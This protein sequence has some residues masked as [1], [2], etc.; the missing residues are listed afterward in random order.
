MEL[1]LREDSTLAPVTGAIVRLIGPA[2]VAAQGLSDAFGRLT[3]RA[4]G[5]GIYRI[6][7][8]RIGMSGILTE[9]Y[10]LAAGQTY[11]R[12][13]RL[14]ARRTELPP[15]V[16]EGRSACSAQGRGGPLASALWEEVRKA[17]TANVLTAES[18]LPLHQREFVRE[19]D[20]RRQPLREWVVVSRLIRGQ[21]FG[22]LAAPDLVRNGFVQEVGDSALFAAPDAGTLLSDAFVATHCFRAVP[23]PEGLLGLAFEPVRGRR[24]PDVA[25]TLWVRR[26]TAELLALEYS[27]T[28]LT[29][30][31]RRAALGGRIEYERLASGAWIVG[32]WHVRM[33]RIAFDLTHLGAGRPPA[34]LAGYLD[35]GGRARVALDTLGR[36]DRAVLLGAIHDSTTGR[37]LAGAFV[38]VLGTADSVLTDAQGRFELAVAAAGD[39]R[40][41]A[42]HPKLG[43][44]GEATSK[45]VLLSLGDTARVAFGVPS[46][47]TFVA[48]LCKDNTKSGTVGIV[49]TAWTS[50]GHPAARREVRAVRQTVRGPIPATTAPGG[51][52]SRSSPAGLFGLCGIP[53]ETEISLILG[54]EGA[55]AAAEL[56]VRLAREPRWVEL[57]EAGGVDSSA[58]SFASVRRHSEADDGALVRRLCGLSPGNA[59]IL[60]IVEDAGR[61]LAELEVRAHWSGAD[62]IR[63]EARGRTGADGIFALC[64]LPDGMEFVVSLSRNGVPL[65]ETR[66][67]LGEAEYRWLSLRPAAEPR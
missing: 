60:G 9:S 27:Y 21:P 51:G 43:L 50:A 59:G 34:V 28:G 1:R 40:V 41:I 24:V 58:V 26:E 5:P 31:L 13:L 35:K 52:K 39:Q 18:G 17:L 30:L 49:G 42:R 38:T 54:A 4:P 55:S 12:E 61:P 63:R 47:A 20:P 36:V 46:P 10:I 22:S 8:D 37:G 2:G 48:L 56:P 62:S 6:R 16:V 19:V 67:R 53:E 66:V 33:P 3:L 45:V 29:G 7:V 44:L 23:G 11:Q 15:L 14:G 25:G 64:G 32:Y 65:G 57:R